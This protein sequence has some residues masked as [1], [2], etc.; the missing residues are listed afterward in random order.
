MTRFKD[1]LELYI[2]TENDA[3]KGDEVAF[4]VAH[5][6][7]EVAHRFEH[8]QFN[9]IIHDINGNKVGGFGWSGRD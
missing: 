1:I 9:G 3:F 7:R 2:H 4:A 8:G 6:L 5:L